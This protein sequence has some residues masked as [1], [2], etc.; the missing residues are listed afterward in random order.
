[1][2]NLVFFLIGRGR[3]MLDGKNIL[4]TGGTGT[5]GNAFVSYILENYNPEKIIVFSRDEYKQFLMKEKFI[6]HGKKLR[7]FVG[8]VRDYGRLR[9]AFNGVDYVI[10]AAALKQ[11]P[12]CEY[13]PIEAV[14]TNIT[15]AENIINAA[16]DAGVKK[17]VALSTD[18]AVN[19]VNLYGA[20]KLVSDKL[21]INGNAY[22]GVGKPVFSVVRYGNVAGSRGSVIPYFRKLI[23]EGAEELPITDF[24]MTRF[25]IYIEEGVKLIIRAIEKSRGG[26]IFVSEIPAFKIVDLARAV[27]DKI[28]LKEIGI[29]P[30]EKLHEVLISTGEARTT[31]KY[32]GYYVVYPEFSWHEGQVFDKKDGKKVEENFCYSSDMVRHL[33]VDELREYLDK[34]VVE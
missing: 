33:S 25:W 19:P 21:I 34:L 26:E 27:D 6:R 14:K 23:S 32:D 29:R 7:F 13:N 12:A 3:V 8:D 1:M 30:G 31:W 16:I 17:V 22:S 24:R 4:I 28:K 10:H 9:R 5:L 15:G 2:E 11:V 18:K 20:T